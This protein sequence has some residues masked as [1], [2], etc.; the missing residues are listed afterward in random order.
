MPKTAA[1]IHLNGQ[2][3]QTLRRWA[4]SSAIRAGLVQR[5]VTLAAA[6]GFPHS[7]SPQVG[8]LLCVLAASGNGTAAE[9][10][11]GYGVGTAWIRSGL[12]SQSRVVT[13]EHDADRAAAAASLFTGDPQVVVVAGTGTAWRTSRR[14]T[15]CFAM[16]AASATT[17][18]W[19][20]SCCS[21]AGSSSW[22]TSRS[23]RPGH[24]PSLASGIG[25]AS[26]G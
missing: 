12:R 17:R 5:A 26:T 13:V 14:S 23:A 16:V 6:H 4:R 11:T 20:S 15:C 25:C 21:L 8:Q 10:G 24:P 19:S 9:S 7:C 18:S 2:D 22:T 1:T 3:E